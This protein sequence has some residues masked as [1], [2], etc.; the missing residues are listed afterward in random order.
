MVGEFVFM[1]VGGVVVKKAARPCGPA[2]HSV[3]QLPAWKVSGGFS[4]PQEILFP[5][6]AAGTPGLLILL[7]IHARAG[8]PCSLVSGLIWILKLNNCTPFFGWH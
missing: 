2:L 1:E 7:M 8:A 4:K 6:P 5:R 3:L